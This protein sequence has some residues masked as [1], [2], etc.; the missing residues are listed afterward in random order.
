MVIHSSILAWRTSW[1]EEPGGLQSEGLQRGRLDWVTNTQVQTCTHAHKHTHTHTHIVM[2]LMLLFEEIY[3]VHLGKVNKK[4][5]CC[6]K[7]SALFKIFILFL[8]GR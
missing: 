8:I 6:L 7:S 4:K 1:T 3:R 2:R 5:L